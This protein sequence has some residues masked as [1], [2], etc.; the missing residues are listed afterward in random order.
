[1]YRTGASHSDGSNQ[2]PMTNRNVMNVELSARAPSPRGPSP[3]H[4][5]L[6]NIRGP[7]PNPGK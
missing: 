6:E 4:G 2:T 1:M 5:F 7:L 3:V